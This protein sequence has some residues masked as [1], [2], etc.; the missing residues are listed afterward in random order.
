MKKIRTCTLCGQ[1]GHNR[2]TCPSPESP[3][4]S[5]SSSEDG[6]TFPVS[7]LQFP[8]TD[9]QDGPGF[10]VATSLSARCRS[11]DS[12]HEID[13]VPGLRGFRVVLHEHGKDPVEAYIPE[14]RVA[15]WYPK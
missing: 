14:H 1:T 2:S 15:I 7:L 8:Y 6:R 9:P 12:R 4:S 10:K 3:E 11:K 13:Y 5:E